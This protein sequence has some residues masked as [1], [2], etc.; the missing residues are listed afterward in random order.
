MGVVGVVGRDFPP[1]FR[2]VLLQRD[3]DLAGVEEKADGLTFHWAGRY[4]GAM[5]QAKTLVTDL[6]VLATFSPSLPEHLRRAPYVFL[7]NTDPRIQLDVLDQLVGPRLVVADTMN[8]WI[9]VAREPL[10]QVLRRVDGL[11]VNDAEARALAR[12]AGAPPPRDADGRAR[13]ESSS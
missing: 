2:D 10:L 12:A 13:F 9:D 4:E 8:L 11:V 5:D 1:R 3:V 6:N 7:A